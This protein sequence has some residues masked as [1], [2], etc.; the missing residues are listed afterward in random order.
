[1]RGMAEVFLREGRQYSKGMQDKPVE[2]FL[3][4]KYTSL[5]VQEVS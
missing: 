4:L 5:V 2:Q 3:I 1:M